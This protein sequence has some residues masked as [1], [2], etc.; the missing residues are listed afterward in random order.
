MLTNLRRGH[1]GIRSSV[2]TNEDSANSGILDIE[3]EWSVD[4]DKFV[5]PTTWASRLVSIGW[6]SA[7]LTG[8]LRAGGSY[9][10]AKFIIFMENV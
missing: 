3:D 8:T 6:M 7:I 5:A 1:D 4:L 9:K 10:S 2:S